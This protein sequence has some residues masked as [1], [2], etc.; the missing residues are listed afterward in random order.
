MT[1]DVH[2]AP[3][4]LIQYFSGVDHVTHRVTFCLDSGMR[5]YVAD[6]LEEWADAVAFIPELPGPPGNP[7]ASEPML[8]FKDRIT[9]VLRGGRAPPRR[10]REE[11]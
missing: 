6:V 9:A 8:V 10:S 5:Y 4:S 3:V 11:D 1:Y 2:P 7:N